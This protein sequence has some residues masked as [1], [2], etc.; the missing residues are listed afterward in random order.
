MARTEKPS[1]SSAG[2]AEPSLVASGQGGKPYNVVCIVQDGRLSYEALI[3][4]ASFRASNPDFQGRLLMAE[5][6]PGP[7]WQGEVRVRPQV[8]DL[9][10]TFGAEIVP[11]DNRSFGQ[12]YPYGNKIE[13][14]LS[15]PQDAPFV[16]FD[17]DTLFTGS[18]SDVA[19]DFER[20]SASM[21]REGSWPQPGLYGPGHDGIWRALYDRF[22]LTFEP[23]WDMRWPADHWQRYLYFNAGWFFHSNPQ[24]FGQRFLDYALSIRDAEIEA[25]ASQSLDPWLD[26]VA[27]PLVIHSFGG[28]RPGPDL[29]GLDGDVTCHYRTLP[30]LYARESDRVVEVLEDV[31]APNRLKKILK[32]HDALKRLVYQ[33]QGQ[34][35]RAL[36]DRAALPR[37]EQAIRQRIKAAGLWLR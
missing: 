19:F 30:L 36:F 10:D 9:L 35:I 23:T 28:G 12:S 27:L 22:G 26:Q 11:F 14:L 1:R 2:Q 8:R 3:F 4:A 21:R 31:T 5:P 37:R 32:E 13:A 16:F 29:C 18:L 20:P 15:L 6:Q 7:L 24:T 33:G 34:K 25:L 17:T